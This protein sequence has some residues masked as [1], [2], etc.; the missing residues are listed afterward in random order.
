MQVCNRRS[1][2]ALPHSGGSVILVIQLG[3]TMLTLRL[4]PAVEQRLENLAMRTGR[5]KTFYA[6][7]AIEERLPD[8]ELAFAPV[9]QGASL[10][11]QTKIQRA[12][13]A[14]KELRRGV[15]KPEGMTVKDMRED[16]RS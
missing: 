12:I 16:G 9:P 3:G 14:L 2:K 8:Y 6:S 10:R 4:K 13:A 5:T 1:G 15:T 11:D 7:K